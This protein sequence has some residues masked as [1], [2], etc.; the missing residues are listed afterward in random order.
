MS[1]F[2]LA[3][4][5]YLLLAVVFVLDKFILSKTVQSPVVYT[6]YSTFFMGA[7]IV[8]YPFLPDALSFAHWMV[9][10]LSGLTFGFGLWAM[11]IALRHG[12]ASHITPFVGAIISVATFAGGS[13]FLHEQLTTHQLFGIVVLV[14][15]S[16]FFSY[17]KS[18]THNGIH[19]GF[20]WAAVSGLLFATSHV[21]A[22]YIYELYPF[23]I[24]LVA[25]KA[26]VGIV[27][28][29]TLCFPAVRHSFASRPKKEK[30]QQT[31]KYI[32]PIVLSNK[33]IGVVAVLLV[34][35]A[36]SL[37]SVTVVNAMSGIQYVC[38]FGLIYMLTTWLPKVFNEY[39]T[40]KEVVT[41]I[42]AL[43]CVV[44]GSVLLVM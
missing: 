27:G 19:W 39:F 40:K 14:I 32:I 21:S 23:A 9:A 5:G 30:K 7:A 42:I 36:I 10:L 37:G 16:L 31:K 24:G 43:L 26:T 6:F 1:W 25:T 33:I 22:K 15:A 28:L 4:V 29:I 34:Q 8:A 13:L 3:L 35:Y 20:A 41:E 38:M 11:F 12:E 18:K 2:L 44:A 17:E